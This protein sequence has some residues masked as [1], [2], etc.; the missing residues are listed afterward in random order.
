VEQNEHD[1]ERKSALLYAGALMGRLSRRDVLKRGATL[2]VS[3]TVLSALLA[4]CGD[5]VAPTTPA[6]GAAPTVAP[7]AAGNTVASTPTKA[8]AITPAASGAAKPALG[9]D[10]VGKLEGPEVITDPAQIPKSFKEAPQLAELVKAGKL[11]PV[12]QRVSQEPIVV[13][14]LNKI[15]K[16]GG[17]WRRAFTGPGDGEN[18]NRIN[19]TDKILFWDYTGNKILPSLAKG[20]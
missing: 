1:N 3:A 20:Y 15:G 11:P 9:A 14:P 16:Y 2:G 4:A 5:T 10:L 18:G 6:T 12:E 19:S 7:A 13:K 17:I 8:A